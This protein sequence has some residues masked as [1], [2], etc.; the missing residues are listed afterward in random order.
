MRWTQPAINYS[1][2]EDLYLTLASFAEDGSV[3]TVN[4]KINPMVDF[5]WLGGLVLIFG[6]VIAMWPDRRERRQ[7]QQ[8]RKQGHD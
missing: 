7:V 6:T 2:K 1:L 4:A 8:R 3:V 5:L